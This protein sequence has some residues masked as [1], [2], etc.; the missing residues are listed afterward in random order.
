MCQKAL[1][2]TEEQ[3]KLI[4]EN[5][6][7]KSLSLDAYFSLYH[8]DSYFGRARL[9]QVQR[10]AGSKPDHKQTALKTFRE[11]LEIVRMRG[12]HVHDISNENPDSLD[13]HGSLL[14][15]VLNSMSLQLEEDERTEQLQVAMM[16]EIAGSDY[17]SECKWPKWA[18][19]KAACDFEQNPSTV[20]T[21][22]ARKKRLASFFTQVLSIADELRA[23]EAILFYCLASESDEKIYQD[24]DKNMY[25]Y[26][27]EDIKRKAKEALKLVKEPGQRAAEKEGWFTKDVEK[28][29]CFRDLQKRCDEQAKELVKEAGRGLKENQQDNKPADAQ[30][31]PGDNLFIAIISAFVHCFNQFDM[32]RMMTLTQERLSKIKDDK[33]KN[34]EE[35]SQIKDELDDRLSKIK[36]IKDDRL[37]KIKDVMPKT[38]YL[39]WGR[40]TVLKGVEKATTWLYDPANFDTDMVHDTLIQEEPLDVLEKLVQE[41]TR[42]LEEVARLASKRDIYIAQIQVATTQF[43][44]LFFSDFPAFERNLACLCH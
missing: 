22:D 24:D 23:S 35:L 10:S 32:K 27:K 4:D 25:G 12:C 11:C 1:E 9:Q 17:I 13:V 38:G 37:S 34:A 15:C 43:I 26:S 42:M 21:K 28:E 29:G 36:K 2:W 39:G 44:F 14:S 31:Q 6:N 8:H 5:V 33:S 19:Q 20:I 41:E 40:D 30:T 18:V 16:R 7:A 3:S